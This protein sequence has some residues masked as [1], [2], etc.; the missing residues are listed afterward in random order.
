MKNLKVK[1][2]AGVVVVGVT[3]Q[4]G[5]GEVQAYVPYAESA[6]EKAST[7]AVVVFDS[8][9]IKAINVEYLEVIGE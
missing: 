5:N 6:Y 3:E 7:K 8:G 1:L 2:K 9:I 4:D